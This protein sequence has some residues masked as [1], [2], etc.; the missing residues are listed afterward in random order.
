MD[1]KRKEIKMMKQGMKFAG[2]IVLV[3]L[4]GMAFKVADKTV[5]KDKLNYFEGTY[6]E[7]LV[8][9]KKEKKAIFIDAYTNWCGW[10][11]E[12][13]KRTFS[14]VDV[15]EYMNAN[16]INMKIDMESTAGIPLANKFRVSSYPTLLFIHH[17]EKVTHRIEG[18]LPASAF[19]KEAR[20]AKKKNNKR[21]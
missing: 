8:K 2:A 11:K 15:A 19:L 4:F 6:E 14:D 21:N 20:F 17:E 12:L 18:F 10:C 5:N 7:A 1:R 3:A 9:A 16:F 13:D